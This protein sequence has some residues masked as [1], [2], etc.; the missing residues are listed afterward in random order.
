MADAR[1]ANQKCI[2]LHAY[3]ALWEEVLC[4][5]PEYDPKVL[6]RYA[7]ASKEVYGEV[8]P[9]LVND[10]IKALKLSSKDVLYDLGSGVG[11]VRPPNG[12]SRS[13]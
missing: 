13:Q 8:N 12:Q 1:R 11:N 10:F 5:T 2:S 7:P 6:R 4:M 3:S 9:V